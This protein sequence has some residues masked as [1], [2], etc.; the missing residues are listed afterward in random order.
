MGSNEA[1]KVEVFNVNGARLSK[2]Q[3]GLVIVKKTMSDGSVKVLKKV[4]K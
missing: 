1:V 4:Q 3:K 2:A